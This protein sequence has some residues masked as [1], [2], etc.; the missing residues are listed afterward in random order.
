MDEFFYL[1]CKWLSHLKEI[2]L[3][4]DNGKCYSNNILGVFSHIVGESHRVNVHGYVYRNEQCAKGLVDNHFAVLKMWVCKYVKEQGED[5][6]C[7]T[8]LVTALSYKGGL[9][10]HHHRA[11]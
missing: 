9:P 8:D 1:L 7:P 5:V 11:F 3:Y 2:F 6:S 10:K 4:S